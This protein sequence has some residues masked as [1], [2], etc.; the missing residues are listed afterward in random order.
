M[1]R[2]CPNIPKDRRGCA[3]RGLYQI[4]MRN[5]LYPNRLTYCYALISKTAEYGLRAVLHIA[6]HDTEVPVRAHEI[7][8]ALGVPANYLSKILHNLARAGILI[9]GRGPRGGFRLAQ[10]PEELRLADVIEPLDPEML[11]L[12]CLLGN[13]QCSDHAS[14]AVHHRWKQVREPVMAFFE[15]TTLADVRRG[16]PLTP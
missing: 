10:S 12:S 9:S 1:G 15:G 6:S 3:C 2:A 16:A 8:Q 11:Q 7:A 5:W 4:H 13:A 14:C